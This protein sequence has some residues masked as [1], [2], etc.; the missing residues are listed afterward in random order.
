MY[1]I[2]SSGT[3]AFLIAFANELSGLAPACWKLLNN[4]FVFKA[5]IIEDW[6]FLPGRK[7]MQ[8][9]LH[10]LLGKLHGNSWLIHDDSLEPARTRLRFF[11][12]VAAVQRPVVP[13]IENI[14]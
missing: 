8:L 6:L 2:S 14:G 12:S 4:L 3:P 9:Q 11:V 13:P 1:L 10:P 5:G 7:V